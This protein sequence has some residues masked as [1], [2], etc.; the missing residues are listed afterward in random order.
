M[1]ALLS[2]CLGRDRKSKVQLAKTKSDDRS[3]SDGVQEIHQRPGA[4]ENQS[5][6]TSRRRPELATTPIGAGTT[7]FAGHMDPANNA[8][9]PE[10]EHSRERH[11]VASRTRLPD[12]GLDKELRV[13][14]GPQHPK[15]GSDDD[16]IVER[17]P[18]APHV[19]SKSL[20]QLEG[21]IQSAIW[22][23]VKSPN[24]TA[25]QIVLP[26]DLTDFWAH[27][28]RVRFIL[29]QSWYKLLP[30]GHEHPMR[31]FHKS[32][33]ILLLVNFREWHRFHEVFIAEP[34]RSDKKIPFELET[35]QQDDFLGIH[36]GQAFYEKQWVFCPYVFKAQ[37]EPH[38][39]RGMDLELRFPYVKTTKPIGEGSS[40]TVC[41]QIV[42]KH[43]LVIKESSNIQDRAVAVKIVPASS[44]APMEFENLKS[45]RRCLVRHKNI[46]VNIAT[47]IREH[48]EGH[49]YH[50]LYDLADFDL[51]E[52]LT[53]D[54]RKNRCKRQGMA[55]PGRNNSHEVWPGELLKQSRNLADALDFLHNRLWDEDKVSLVHNDLR[56]QNILVYYLDSPNQADKYPVGMWKIADFG[57]AK[58]KD[59]RGESP[60]LGSRGFSSS[61]LSPH[62][63]RSNSAEQSLTHRRLSLTSAKR[64]AG[65]YTPPEVKDFLDQLNARMGDVWGFGCVLAEVVAYAAVGYQEV[66]AMRKACE[67][68][69]EDRFFD[70]E[71]KQL[72]ETF[73]A[74]LKDLP[75]KQHQKERRVQWLRPCTDLIT[76]ILK[77]KAEER[78]SP[79]QIRDR[80]HD[81]LEK[82]LKPNKDLWLEPLDTSSVSGPGSESGYSAS[83]KEMDSADAFDEFLGNDGDHR[84][85]TNGTVPVISHST[86]E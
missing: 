18:F 65:R 73:I 52:F 64:P 47:I 44:V 76:D 27:P 29:G 71:S 60:D 51:E 34:D 24:G 33:S 22:T 56:P 50:I 40:G 20:E 23:I 31:D 21:D 45:L 4:T 6:S 7:G 1:G 63:A 75:G 80:L 30:K 14:T 85:W 43:H 72:K 61:H 35:L 84:G 28:E 25:A 32:F 11:P 55:P 83:P 42:A 59:Q 66:D 36:H 9:E 26:E 82:H 38:K 49:V 17:R 48:A 13:E 53:T 79:R 70:A 19:T 62:H 8:Q 3:T 77:P 16:Q 58:I 57:L 69:K 39:L 15:P 2:I 78:L 5:L 12:A 86:H 67:S 68:A 81:V 10:H 37:Q 74:W 54:W 46:M 41:K